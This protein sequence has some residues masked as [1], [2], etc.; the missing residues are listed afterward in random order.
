MTGA[1]GTFVAVRPGDRVE[2]TP[3]GIGTLT[4]M[5]PDLQPAATAKKRTTTHEFTF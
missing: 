5:S 3:G 2:S 4:N 1:P